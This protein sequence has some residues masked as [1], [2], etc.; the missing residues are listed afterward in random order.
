NK[1]E[2]LS[3]GFYDSTSSSSSTS[4]TS[5]NC[6]LK[7]TTNLLFNNLANKTKMESSL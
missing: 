6:N 1:E 4:S 5:P 3:S 2:N 7:Q